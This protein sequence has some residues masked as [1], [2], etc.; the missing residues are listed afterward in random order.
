[1]TPQDE[2]YEQICMYLGKRL[3]FRSCF[4]YDRVFAFQV[5]PGQRL[6]VVKDSQKVMWED[7]LPDDLYPEDAGK[8]IPLWDHL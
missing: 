5:R 2:A 7:D 6:C 8:Q 3:P 1:M 4:E